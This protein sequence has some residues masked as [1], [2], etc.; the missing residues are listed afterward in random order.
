M[1]LTENEKQLLWITTYG[2]IYNTIFQ[3]DEVLE[4]LADPLFQVTAPVRQEF[5][6]H[7]TNSL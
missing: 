1:N 4:T 7:V 3:V 2:N 6:I 5:S